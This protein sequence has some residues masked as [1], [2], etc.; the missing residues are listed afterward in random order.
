MPAESEQAP[1]D[2]VRY[3][4]SVQRIHT[5]ALLIV[6]TA[7]E[8]AAFLRNQPPGNF[9]DAAVKAYL[10]CT[11][12]D[13]AL[14]AGML[15][16]DSDKPD[17]YVRMVRATT[18]SQFRIPALEIAAHSPVPAQVV[19]FDHRSK[20]DRAYAAHCFTLPFIFDG[21]ARW[22]DSPMMVHATEP[23]TTAVTEATRGLISQFVH[24]GVADA[25]RY[26]AE[27]PLALTVDTRGI[28]HEQAHDAVLKL[29]EA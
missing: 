24:S 28:R 1:A 22:R 20:L 17:A 26:N 10:E 25:N 27:N 12:A 13:P 5:E 23:E 7:E 14:A 9:S 29:R 11:F 18:L 3:A 16:S 8:S 21:T 15:E 6:T 19:R 2:L 4:D